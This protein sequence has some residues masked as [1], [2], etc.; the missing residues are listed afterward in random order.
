M[1][2]CYCLRPTKLLVRMTNSDW[3]S[4]VLLLPLIWIWTCDPMSMGQAL[5]HY[6]YLFISSNIILIQILKSRFLMFCT[7]YKTR[8]CQIMVLSHETTTT[9][10]WVTMKHESNVNMFLVQCETMWSNV[11]HEA[12]LGFFSKLSNP[13]K[14]V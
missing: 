1:Y 14:N 5:Y 7:T 11:K 3:E 4:Q 8:Q 6:S 9:V 13:K 12:M 10:G 2:S